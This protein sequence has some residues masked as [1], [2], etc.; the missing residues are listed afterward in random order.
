MGQLDLFGSSDDEEVAESSSSPLAHLKFGEEEYPR[1]QLLAHEREMLGLYASAHPLDGA[2]HILRKHAPKPIAAI[3]NDPANEGEVVI[4]GLIIALERRG[5][6]KGR[7]LG[8]LH[9][10]GHGR[11]GR[12]AFFANAYSMFAADVIE[13]QAVLVKCRVNWA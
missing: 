3:L 2:E 9:G 12:G 6:Q 1:K 5:Q 10:R 7:A 11:C 8:D 13:D 4:S